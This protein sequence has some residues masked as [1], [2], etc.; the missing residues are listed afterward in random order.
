MLKQLKPCSEMGFNRFFRLLQKSASSPYCRGGS[1][2]PLLSHRTSFYPC[3]AIIPRAVFSA[4]ADI[5]T[6]AAID[7]KLGFVVNHIQNLQSDKTEHTASK[8]LDEE[9]SDVTEE[10]KGAEFDSKL[11]IQHP[12]P[13]WISLMERLVENNYFESIASSDEDE[14]GS[15]TSGMF[16]DLNRVRNACLNFGRDRFD[17]L[18]SLSREDIKAIVEYGCPSTDRKVVNSGKRLRAYVNLDEGD[19][20]SACNLRGSCD[21]AYVK[22]RQEEGARTVDIM[23]FLL[24]YGL[25]PLV[26]S[27]ENKLHMKKT[28][29]VSVR[30]LLKEVIEFS[31]TPVDPILPN[32]MAKQSLPRMKQSP[33]LPMK[34]PGITDVEMKKGDWLCPRCNIIIFARKTACIQCNETRPKRPL[35][36]GEWYCPVCDFINFSRNM[37][38]LKCDY[39]RPKDDHMQNAK[40]VWKDYRTDAMSDFQQSKYLE[41]K[42]QNPGDWLC[43]SCKFINFKRN[44]ACLKCDCKR[45]KDEHTHNSRQG[46][47][48]YQ[49]DAV[50]NFQ[51]SKHLEQ[52]L[53]NPDRTAN[54]SNALNDEYDHGSISDDDLL[55]GVRR[56][57]GHSINDGNFDFDDFPVRGGKSGSAVGRKKEQN[58]KKTFNR[59]DLGVDKG[60]RSSSAKASHFSDLDLDDDGV[61]DLDLDDDDDD[62]DA[63]DS[64]W[65]K[66][67]SGSA[68]EK[69]GRDSNSAREKG[70]ANKYDDTDDEDGWFGSDQRKESGSFK[71][72]SFLKP[73]GEKNSFK[74]FGDLDLDDDDDDLFESGDEQPQTSRLKLRGEEAR[75]STREERRTENRRVKDPSS[76]SQVR[77][78]VQNDDDFDKLIDL[79]E[80]ED[81]QPQIPR[82]K[83]REEE[84]RPAGRGGYRI[85]SK[86]A[87]EPSSAS[88]GSGREGRR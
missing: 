76:A 62:E 31:A 77:G 56:S 24:T 30:K 32:P 12:W 40:Q 57:R 18:R 25:D 52:K 1:I 8:H 13:E 70:R 11:E 17:I 48:D 87:R 22:A 49:T 74:N 21:R 51:Q 39:K 23:R 28:V 73:I 71:R 75:S 58:E 44:I 47:N 61:S 36:P 33:L 83:L 88:R 5:E 37:T 6:A 15:H 53:K 19:V 80:S 29:K 65:K 78:S 68:S 69:Y 67:S 42:L 59:R 14:E 10:E 86:R 55:N 38:C 45:P 4:N 7:P 2:S 85:E 27:A 60:L 9:E 34:R 20:C 50:D 35:N 3:R 43:P 79:F 64:N 16:K 41:Q 84:T 81:E 82:S 72:S 46:L 26:G 66:A 54:P 63:V